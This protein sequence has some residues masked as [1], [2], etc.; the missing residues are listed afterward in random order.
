MQ[1]KPPGA[2]AVGAVRATLAGRSIEGR[3]PPPCVAA[4]GAA[5]WQSTMRRAPGSG[6]GLGLGRGLGLGAAVWR[7]TTARPALR[8]GARSRCRP[9]S[10]ARGSRDAAVELGGA[11]ASRRGRSRCASKTVFSSSLALYVRAELAVEAE[12]QPVERQAGYTPVSGTSTT[13]PR[14]RRCDRRPHALVRLEV[15]CLTWAWA[16]ARSRW[17]P[18]KAALPPRALRPCEKPTQ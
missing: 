15:W 17:G 5:V 13:R 16:E 12:P 14:P 1:L 9:L 18:R 4:N 6:L 8:R 7:S 10:R 3:L 2:V 11:G